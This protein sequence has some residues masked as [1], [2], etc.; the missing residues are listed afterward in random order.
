MHNFTLLTLQES[1]SFS[2]VLHASLHKHCVNIFLTVKQVKT[3]PVS[4]ELTCSGKEMW[5]NEPSACRHQ[6]KHSTK[7]ANPPQS[8]PKIWKS[9]WSRRGF[10]L[11][12]HRCQKSKRW[13]KI[14][15]PK[16]IASKTSAGT[17]KQQLQCLWCIAKHHF[18]DKSCLF[19]TR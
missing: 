11:L 8:L 15:R 14:L 10:T 19:P 12:H 16:V 4:P 6:R 7:N 5:T 1:F 13:E 9:C 3:E 2:V 18:T 17:V